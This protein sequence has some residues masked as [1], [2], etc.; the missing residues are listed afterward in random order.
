MRDM[1]RVMSSDEVAPSSTEQC[2]AVSATAVTV[3]FVTCWGTQHV[4]SVVAGP[5]GAAPG[6]GA[7]TSAPIPESCAAHCSKQPAK[8]PSP[9]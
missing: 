9:G 6:T 8:P 1:L 7:H 3:M 5:N 2:S 4:A